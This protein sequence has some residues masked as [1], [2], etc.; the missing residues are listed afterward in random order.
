MTWTP[1]QIVVSDEEFKAAH[2][3]I[4]EGKG[5]RLV[6]QEFLAA[7]MPDQAE[8]TDYDVFAAKF[9]ALDAVARGRT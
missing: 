8:E 3:A 4:D 1:D 5:L 9:A 6:L 7:R 2:R